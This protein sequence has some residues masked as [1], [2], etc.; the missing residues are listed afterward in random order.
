MRRDPVFVLVGP[1]ASGKSTIAQMLVERQGMQRAITTTTRHQRRG[2]PFDAY[3][4][5]KF[6][7]FHPED[8]VE[9][10]DYA[11]N[12]YGLTKSEADA[13][14]L[15]I[16]EPVGAQ[17]FQVYCKEKGR[18]CYL[19]GMPVSK[20]EQAERMVQRGDSAS[21]IN[22]RIA[23]DEVAFEHLT[24][25]CTTVCKAENVE[26]LYKQIEEFILSHSVDRVRDS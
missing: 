1:S 23:Y 5:V 10:K 14:N 9:Y 7:E 6:S 4:F 13:S 8:M 17:R 25:V 26:S 3:H 15:V 11:K 20:K 22:E 19:I 21:L 2:E 12:R 24:S 18:Q 16:M